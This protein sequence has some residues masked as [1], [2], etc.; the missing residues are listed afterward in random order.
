MVQR[1]FAPPD[2]YER[3]AASDV[4]NERISCIHILQGERVLFVLGFEYKFLS[5]PYGLLVLL[6]FSSYFLFIKSLNVRWRNMHRTFLDFEMEVLMPP[7]LILYYILP[8]VPHVFL[9]QKYLITVQTNGE[10]TIQSL[11]SPLL[12][13]GDTVPLLLVMK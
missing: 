9:I 1:H 11:P 3:T 6:V 2:H 8:S 12:C 13:P 5:S 7:I 4:S 10:G